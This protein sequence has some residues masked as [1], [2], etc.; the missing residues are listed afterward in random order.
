MLDKKFLIKLLDN[1][2][3]LYS[4]EVRDEYANLIYNV[5]KQ[6]N[7]TDEELKSSVRG[8]IENETQMFNKLPNL[9]IFLKYRP[10]KERNIK[11]FRAISYDQSDEEKE[12]IKNGFDKLIKRLKEKK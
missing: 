10:K 11:T 8:I 6:Y 12:Y 2:A 4:I 7:F 9:A 1:L 5:L 3:I